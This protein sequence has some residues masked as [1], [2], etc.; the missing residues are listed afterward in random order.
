M[1]DSLPS[2]LC[3]AP[4][5]QITTHPSG[6][7]SPCPYLG[8]TS[9]LKHD[10]SIIEKWQGSELE[11]LRQEFLAGKKPEICF[12]CWNEESIGKRS[13][14]RRL[15]DMETETSEYQLFSDPQAIQDLMYSIVDGSYKKGPK[16]ISIKNG[17]VCNLKC[18]SCHP[19]DSSGWIQDAN[20]LHDRLGKKFYKIGLRESNWSDAQIDQLRGL[21]SNLSRLELF[22]GEPL[23]NKKVIRLLNYLVE[24]GSSKHISLYVNTN[25]SVDITAKIPNIDQFKDIDIGVSIDAI[26]E[27]FTYV[28]HPLT[29]DQ[30]KENVRS[31]HRYFRSKN[32]EYNIQSITTVSIL[33]IFYLAEL[34]RTVKSIMGQTPFWNLLIHPHHLSIVNLPQAVKNVV[35]EK[36]RG[37]PEFDEFI[38]FMMNNP[39]SE[40]EWR[41]FFT[42]RDALDDIRGEK[43][44][45]VFP[46]FASIIN[47][48]R[49]SGEGIKIFIGDMAQSWPAQYLTSV[50]LDHD[51]HSFM[52]AQGENNEIKIIEPDGVTRSILRNELPPGTYHT[53]I[54]KWPDLD[55]L[56]WVLTHAK[57][58]YYAPPNYWSDGPEE[59]TTLLPP[60]GWS[61]IVTEEVLAKIPKVKRLEP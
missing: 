29:L 24:D 57:E 45:Q 21:A 37:D 15:F 56:H 22:G 48:H 32:M 11:N 30:I 33:N 34:K 55:A 44:D 46:E 42:I 17:N 52:L 40:D 58:V 10:G 51:P 13:L 25:G 2:T 60:H 6:S 49:L 27:H 7:F 3:I 20:K 8:G 53:G 39:A 23:Y 9:W 31:W 19:D 12:R 26:A 36:L 14:R 35:V 16:V 38:N 59:F 5:A 18:R 28:R 43:F 50:A 41:T 61:K 54:T 1:I 4:F 47:P